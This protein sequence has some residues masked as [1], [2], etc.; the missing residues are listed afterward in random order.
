MK[1]SDPEVE[2]IRKWS[3]TVNVINVNSP[4]DL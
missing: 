2:P 1:M 4:K 3:P